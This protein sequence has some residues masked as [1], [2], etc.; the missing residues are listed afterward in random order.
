MKSRSIFWP[1][2]MIAAGVLWLLRGMGII[3]TGNLWA[4]THLLPYLLMALGAGLILRAYQPYAGMLVSTLI[5]IGAVLVVAFAPQLGWAGPPGWGWGFGPDSGGAIAGS[6]V[7]ETQTRQVA[8]FSAV[9]IGY[10]AEVLI[11]QSASQS[12]AIEAEDNLLPQL[13]TDVRNGVLYI[14]NSEWDWSQRVHPT[15][16]VRINITVEELRE[17]DFSSAV[18][19]RIEDVY[20]DSLE[21]NISGAGNMTLSNLNVAKFTIRLSGAG[22]VIADGRA[23]DIELHISGLA[24]FNGGKLHGQTAEVN[25]SGAG[26]ATLW[27]ERQLSA[28]ISGTG[29]VGYYGSPQVHE[30]ISGA[31][32]V[33]KLGDK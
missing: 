25:I 27:L 6:G 29:S 3:P 15:E 24:S 16:T 9:S 18:A 28:V 22:S 20:G 26:E 23:D 31:G 5:V 10:P 4:L 32:D 33:K 19:G 13:H 17:V 12:V 14:D 30:Q 8:E 21:I 2:V 7:I 1:L 11:Q